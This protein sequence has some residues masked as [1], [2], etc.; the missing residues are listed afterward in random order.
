MID[1]EAAV[2]DRL[3][4]RYW[5]VI[6]AFGDDYYKLPTPQEL[7]EEFLYWRAT[8]MQGYD[9]FAWQWPRDRPA[10]WL[11]N[12]PDLQAQLAKENTQ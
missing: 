3:G 5:G 2:P 11:A 8:R 6:Q 4:I 7:H 10:L 9:V 12:H 1:R